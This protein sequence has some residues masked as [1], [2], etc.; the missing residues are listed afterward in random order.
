MLLFVPASGTLLN[1]MPSPLHSA[2]YPPCLVFASILY[3]TAAQL[4]EHFMILKAIY[5]VSP[6]HFSEFLSSIEDIAIFFCMVI[7]I[8]N[9]YKLSCA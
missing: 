7:F 1:V 2:C 4:D 5:F 8:I 6:F 3:E 9:G